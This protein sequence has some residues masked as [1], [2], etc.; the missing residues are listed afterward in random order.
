M[1]DEGDKGRKQAPPIE[2]VLKPLEID[3]PGDSE[4]ASKSGYCILCGNRPPT[5]RERTAGIC[6]GCMEVFSEKPDPTPD[7]SGESDI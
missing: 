1:A 2:E 4:N 3:E 5:I 7:D 6:D